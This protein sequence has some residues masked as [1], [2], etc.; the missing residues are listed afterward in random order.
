MCLLKMIDIIIFALIAFFIGRKLYKTLGD[1]SYDN[2]MSEENK[3][4]YEQFKEG[5]LKDVEQVQ[6][7]SQIDILSAL[8]A[9]MGEQERKIFEDIREHLPDF[10][11]DKFLLGAKSAFQMILEAYAKQQVHVL[12]KLVSPAMLSQF[13]DSIKQLQA[14]AQRQNITIVGVQNVK[15]LNVFKQ[16]VSAV[17]VVEF[18][19]EQ[20]SNVVDA[21]SG[22]LINGSLSKVI[23]RQ[24][25]WTFSKKINSK[26]NIW[27][28]ISNEK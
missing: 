26:S 24:D 4:A 12:E 13:S 22:E 11:A 27:I 20:I 10:T 2:E 17:I 16:D 7:G 19:S 8:E 14:N 5:L 18:E 6:S 23:K 1:T 25:V 3:K 9:E 28:L 15:I 21:N